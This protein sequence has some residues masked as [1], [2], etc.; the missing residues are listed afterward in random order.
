MAEGAIS[1]V[2]GGFERLMTSGGVT[3]LS[4]EQLLDRFVSLRD[5]SAFEAIVLRHGPM[6]RGVCRR[7]LRDANDV[8][9]A[10]QATFLVLA[11]KAN[12]LRRR[13]RLGTWL[14]GVSYRI[15]SRVRSNAWRRSER[16]SK[17]DPVEKLAVYRES[18]PDDGPT[19]HEEI[20][21]LPENYRVAVVLCYLEG[22]THEEAAARLRW[23]VGTVKGR[24]SRARDLLRSRLDRRGVSLGTGNMAALGELLSLDVETVLPQTL[25]EST[26]KA[27]TLV[28]AGKSALASGLISVRALTLSQGVIHTMFLTK[29][30]AAVAT[31]AIAATVSTGAGV[32]AYQFVDSNGPAKRGSPATKPTASGPEGGD[33]QKSEKRVPDRNP[34][35]SQEAQFENLLNNTTDWT[36]HRIDRLFHWSRAMKDAQE[37]L[38]ESPENI[39]LARRAHR[40]RMKR[41]HEKTQQLQVA[42][43]SKVADTAR[44]SLEAAE[45]DLAKPVSRAT[46]SPARKGTT[47][48]G[49]AGPARASTP[50]RPVAGGGGFGG[51]GGGAMG[52][53]AGEGILGATGEDRSRIAIAEIAPKL[54]AADKSA[55]T[56]A[57]VKKLEEP[58]AVSFP[59]ETSLEDVLKYIKSASQDKSGPGI[60]IYVDPMGLQEAEKTMSSTVRIEL[61]GVPLKTTLRLMLKQLGL[62][63]CVRDGVLIISSPDGIMQELKE[64]MREAPPEVLETIDQRAI[65]PVRA[66]AN[67][68]GF[69]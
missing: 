47:K 8:D 26:V 32:Y 27:A 46:D 61:D 20:H 68:G 65:F 4:E 34:G 51:G 6:V 10:F 55:R 25:V 11:R 16:E 64:A 13:E 49:A 60:P 17:T 30:K 19:L 5:E 57:I 7:L 2:V 21:R 62:A 38:D 67:Q 50:P 9:D 1:A 44:K 66:R 37:Y 18:V 22:L 48:Q 28:A 31:F 43:Q 53:S 41:L 15:A 36:P 63:Y 56:Q 45:G 52:E 59:S 24:L 23:P 42:D 40:D 12:S 58:I 69:Q 29:L 35:A 14:Y 54:A 39:Q 3:G 33:F